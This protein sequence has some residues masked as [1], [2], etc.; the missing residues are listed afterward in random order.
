MLTQQNEHADDL[1]QLLL[2]LVGAR[3]KRMIYFWRGW[4]CRCAEMLG[5]S[6]QY[7]LD[8]LRFDWECFQKRK[9]SGDPGVQAIIARSVFHL[10]AVI[11]LVR[12]AIKH[13]W[14]LTA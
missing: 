3:L 7:A 8:E 13:K 14:K 12:V 1:G 9:D 5:T 4:T 10:V 2:A 6:G 11:Q